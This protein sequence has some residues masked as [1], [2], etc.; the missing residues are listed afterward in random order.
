[1]L[2]PT[3]HT[4]STIEDSGDSPVLRS[5]DQ[6]LPISPFT[7]LFGRS[8]AIS[9]CL[10]IFAT[11]EGEF[12]L[13]FVRAFCHKRSIGVCLA[14]HLIEIQNVSPVPCR[15]QP[16]RNLELK[17]SDDGTLKILRSAWSGRNSGV[18]SS[19]SLTLDSMM[20][21]SGHATNTKHS[22]SAK[23]ANFAGLSLPTLIVYVFL[24]LSVSIF[25]SRA[26]RWR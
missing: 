7:L 24:P 15:R 13:A 17:W 9:F 1:M 23:L 16:Q 22:I 4:G 19:H 3:R 10:A 18:F 6:S 25:R 14:D 2:N 11:D 12:R 21:F 5:R 8:C 20:L 26:I